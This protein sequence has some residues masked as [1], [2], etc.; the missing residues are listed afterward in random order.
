[1]VDGLGAEPSEVTA[2]RLSYRL[3]KLRGRGVLHTVVGQSLHSDRSRYRA[4]LYLTTLYQ[5][6]HP[7]TL[8]SVTRRILSR[9]ELVQYS[10]TMA[11]VTLSCEVTRTGG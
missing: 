1:M 5:R 11:L 9:T 7:P 10:W 4:A 3:A 6:L 2:A 8:D